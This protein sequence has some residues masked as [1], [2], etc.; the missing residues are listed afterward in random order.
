MGTCSRTL[1]ALAVCGS[2]A[3]GPAGFA[4]AQEPWR[5]IFP[6]Q[7]RMQIRAPGAM[8]KARLP[9][10]PS[11]PTVSDPQWD[12]RGEDFPLDEA[13]RTALANSEVV[14]VL[15]GT[16]ATSSGRTIYDPALTNT[17]IDQA[18]GRF[19]PAVDVRNGFNHRE[20]PGG[21]DPDDP[22]QTIAGVPATDDY[23]MS[24]GLSKTT[25]TGGSLRLGVTAVPTRVNA[26][27]LPLN[28]QTGSATELSLSQPLLKGG[29]VRRNLAPVVLARIDTERSFFQLKQ[30]VQ[31]SVRGVIEA[32]WALVFSRTD[33]WVRQ[34]QVI[35]GEEALL[36][37]SNRL[38]VGLTDSA[39]VAQARS[40]LA[41][42]RASQITAE[43]DLLEREAALWNIMGL[44]PQEPVR[45]I[46]VTPP[47]REQLTADWD[48]VVS[49][50]EERRPD[51]IEL[52]LILEADQQRLL[53]A[54]NQALP[55]VDAVALYRWNGL[56]GTTPG[57][58]FAS[59][60]PGEFTSWQLGVNFSVP[61]GLRQARAELRQ[62]E[63]IIMRDRAN[64]QQG[65]HDVT[66][67]LA[68]SFRN[69]A[70]AYQQYRAFTESRA[71]AQINLMHQRANY[72][73]HRTIYLNVLQAITN[74][75]TAV[76]AEAQALT[77]YNVELANLELQTGTILETHG[78]RFFE[79]RYGSVGPLGRIFYDRC[80]PR[81]YRPGPNVD[82]YPRGSQP[83][84][85]T[86]NLEEPIRL[87]TLKSQPSGGPLTNPERLRL[88]VPEP[89]PPPGPQP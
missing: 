76:S 82:Q 87:P 85:K 79:E 19:D 78:V 69:L 25:A 26:P 29:G 4:D 38:K 48:T 14:R 36:V 33:L 44:P 83:A 89:I 15:A 31:Q 1:V 73:A 11:P 88:E 43:A 57:G 6:E 2:W 81:D 64:L 28:P 13:I 63:L 77:R 18:R 5:P 39:E 61:I 7:R 20:S 58:D 75:G 60:R 32:Y 71:A 10:L 42:F 66:H 74:W 72:Q 24:M 22:S 54:R 41:S 45:M 84:E 55:Q 68:A 80:Y 8:P 34:Q 37:A 59:T 65:L 46:P 35:Q 86:F 17:G 21:I 50:A 23:Q 62:Q 16:T 40:A 67:S 30:S 47:T 56:E 3:L 52:K 12:A 51:L 27:G 53:T 70:Q 9:R 49:L